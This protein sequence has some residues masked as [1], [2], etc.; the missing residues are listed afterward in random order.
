VRS[1]FLIVFAAAISILVGCLGR[2]GPPSSSA[3]L[4]DPT[5]GGIKIKIEGALPCDR[6]VQIAVG[7]LRERAPEQLARGV[8]AIDVFLTT[9]PRGEVPPQIDCGSEQFAQLVTITFEAA[10]PGGPI[11]PSLTVAVA[12]VSGAILGIANPL[13]L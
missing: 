3:A 7:A 4:P 12:P 1:P 2:T 6:I 8:A 5:C 13:I 9:C 10:P 11:E